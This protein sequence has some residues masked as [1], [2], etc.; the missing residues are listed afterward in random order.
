MKPGSK[1]FFTGGMILSFIL[2]VFIVLRAGESP[3][4]NPFPELKSNIASDT[5]INPESITEE[6]YTEISIVNGRKKVKETIIKKRGDEIIEKKVIER[7]ED[8]MDDSP[9]QFEYN[10][11]EFPSTDTMPFGLDDQFNFRFF[12]LDSLMNSFRFRFDGPSF[13]FD[14]RDR[15]NG[16]N[17]LFERRDNGGTFEFSPFGGDIDKMMDEMLRR[18]NFDFGDIPGWEE[19]G[20]PGIKPAP[21]T[22]NE[23]ITEKLLIDGIISDIDQNYRFDI[24]EK[25]LRINGKKQ[26][27]ALYEKYKKLIEENIGVE[28]EDEF[29]FNFNNN[30]KLESK[31]KR[32]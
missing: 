24:D 30:K 6:R 23:I 11:R 22:L 29:S 9:F 20:S 8:A 13:D 32:L 16:G 18:Y 17:E 1:L 26:E 25:E 10:F 31:I 4:L 12:P 2:L 28:L 3:L 7:D 5:L 21:K 19:R 15:L 27:Q 14:F